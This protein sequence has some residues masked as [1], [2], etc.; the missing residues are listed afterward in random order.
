M[1]KLNGLD[2]FSGIG[3]ITLAIR[4]WV[5]PVAYCEI[6]RYAQG[7]LLSRMAA[8][9]LP[10][11]PIWDDVSSL[12]Q[13]LLPG[14]D[15]IYGGFPCQDISVA[16]NGKGL[17]GERSGLFYE[18]LRLAKECRPTFVFLENVPAIRTRGLASVIRGFTEIG[19]DCRW[20][21]LS[22]ADVG[23]NHK[24][25]RW[26]F[27]ARSG[28]T[29]RAERSLRNEGF[30]STALGRGASTELKRSGET[31]GPVAH[32]EGIGRPEGQQDARRCGERE[33]TLPGEEQCG[34]VSTSWWD[35]E[36]NVGR[37][38]DGI[39]NR[40]DRLKCLG[41]AVVPLQAKTAFEILMG[42]DDRYKGE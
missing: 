28:R 27:L 10:A 38:V 21:C 9:D 4:E 39:P 22:A 25:E 18:I 13:S 29:R 17:E 23:A 24:R 12:G 7:V 34:F 42:L 1:E 40:V 5:K 11:A 14:L 3:G 32:A 31:C 33:G 35:V 2:L 16:G 20:T 19:Y 15:I 26:F 36:P 8:G 6:D 37:V 41:N 30:A